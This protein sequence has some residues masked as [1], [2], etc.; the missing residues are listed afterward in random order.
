MAF[1]GPAE[2]QGAGQ[3][4]VVVEEGLCH[5]LSHRLEAGKVDHRVDGVFLE[6]L[7]QLALVQ[8]IRLIKGEVPAGQGADGVQD[9][10]FGVGEVV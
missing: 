9:L 1:H 2:V 3:V 5:R 7:L 4:V 8:Q 10:R 6:N